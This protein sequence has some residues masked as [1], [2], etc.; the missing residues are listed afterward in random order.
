MGKI[1]IY[2]IAKKLNLASKEVVEMAGKLN[3]EVKNHMSAVSE[4]DAE[5]IANKFNSKTEKEAKKRE[6]TNKV[7]EE[8]KKEKKTTKTEPKNPK[9]EEK[10][11]VII[12][13]EVLIEEK[14]KEEVKK[15]NKTNNVGFVERKQNKD[16][17]IVYRN[18]PNKP[19]TVSELFGLNKETKKEE[20]KKVEEQPKQEVDN[21]ELKAEETNKKEIK[22]LAKIKNKKQEE[23][24]KSEMELILEKLSSKDNGAPSGYFVEM[25]EKEEGRPEESVKINTTYISTIN[26]SANSTNEIKKSSGEK[27][28]VLDFEIKEEKN[29]ALK[30]IADGSRSHEEKKALVDVLNVFFKDTKKEVAI[31]NDLT[32]SLKNKK[33][34]IEI[35]KLS[36]GERQL[37]YTFLR[38]FNSERENQIIL[39]DEPEISLHL[40]WQEI[41]ISSIK[42]IREDCQIILVTHSPGIVMDGWMGAYKEIDSIITKSGK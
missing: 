36:S 42:K 11:P 18:K 31:E 12:R 27:V 19:L 24:I 41:L 38:V 40:S 17:N 4:E 33:T 13:R 35:E 21:K 25:S 3:I 39:L 16:F 14:G 30:K 22:E 1:K 37:I 23:K 5:K 34:T 8:S 6:K 26:M 28:M 15:Q 9:K 10:A 20:P 32:V 7:E 29:A 2:E